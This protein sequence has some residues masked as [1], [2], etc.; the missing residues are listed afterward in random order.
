[1]EW[2][3]KLERVKKKR[4]RLTVRKKQPV[5]RNSNSGRHFLNKAFVNKGLSNFDL[6]EWIDKLRIKHFSGIY[7][8]NALPESI[9]KKN[10]E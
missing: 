7:S 10:V 9:K 5:Q 1:M 3:R 6:E 4:Q 2:G 8:R